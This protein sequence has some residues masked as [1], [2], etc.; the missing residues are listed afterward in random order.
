MENANKV[1]ESRLPDKAK[2]LGKKKL[3]IASVAILLAAALIVGLVLL[4]IPR[5]PALSYHGVT[6]DDEMYAFWYAMLKTEFM[7]A[8]RLSG[9]EH[10]KAEVWDLPCPREGANGRTWGEVL[11]DDI[12]RAIKLKL[13]SAVMYDEL[14]LEMAENQRARVESY[15]DDMREYVADGSSATLRELLEEHRTTASALRRCAV[16]DLKSELLWYQLSLG[17]AQGL[18]DNWERGPYL[19]ADELMAEY[20]NYHCVKI[21]YINNEVY[22]DYINGSRVEIPLEFDGPGAQNDTDRLELDAYIENNAKGLTPEKFAE[23]IRRSDEAIHGEGAYP[24]GIYFTD[25]SDLTGLLETAVADAV[26]TVGIGDLARVETPRG[27]RYIYGCEKETGAY[28]RP[29][30]AVFFTSFFSDAAEAAIT[31]RAAAVLDEVVEYTENTEELNVYT[32]P[33]NKKFKL[34]TMG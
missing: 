11:D 32:I 15:Y 18:D 17:G 30:S 1:F 9:D 22:G 24:S 19:D 6:V 33:Y 8:Y 2:R 20:E 13:V 14:G 29:E 7:R 26:H 27:V 25:R 16:F 10:D 4:L 34:C 12:R 31:A 21:V 28:L 3:L 23:Y 5:T